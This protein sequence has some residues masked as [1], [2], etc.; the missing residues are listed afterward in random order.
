M[1]TFDFISD[2]GH[3]W[4]KVP[5]KLLIDLGIDA[6]ISSYSYY[7]DGFAYLEEDLDAGTFFRAM[8]KAGR[9]WKI[10]ERVARERWSKIRGYKFY[11]PLIAEKLKTGVQ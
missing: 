4:I 11:V 9:P 2:P 5:V 3:G 1:K 6:D 7:R 8:D 10:R